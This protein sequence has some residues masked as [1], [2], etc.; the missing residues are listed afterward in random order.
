MKVGSQSSRGDDKAETEVC[1]DID[2]QIIIGTR[3]IH[4]YHLPDLSAS[5]KTL[6][7]F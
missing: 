3:T 6:E 1:D 4:L 2:L 7:D 5:F